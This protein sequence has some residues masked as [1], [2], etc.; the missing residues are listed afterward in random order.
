MSTQNPASP[1]TRG[2]RL[3]AVP[4]AASCARA[5]AR[6]TLYAW[7][8]PDVVEST[9]LIT[10]ELVTNA[11]RATGTT[12]PHPTY[13]ALATVP[14]IRVQLSLHRAALIVGVWDVSSNTPIPQPQYQDAEHGRGLLIVHTQSERWGT[15]FFKT[16][17][18]VV[19]AE[20]ALRAAAKPHTPATT[21]RTTA[22]TFP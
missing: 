3:A 19:W 4:T 5:F 2:L 17:G 7:Q 6:H 10:S 18:K 8:C 11:V 13:G 15:C 9:A 22:H 14:V 1:S 12:D 20:I 16:G 21:T